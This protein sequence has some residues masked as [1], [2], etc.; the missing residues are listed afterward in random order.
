M[1]FC[2]FTCNFQKL[3]VLVWFCRMFLQWVSQLFIHSILCLLLKWPPGIMLLPKP[4][5]NEEGLSYCVQLYQSCS[6]LMRRRGQWW[7]AAISG[8]VSIIFVCL[9]VVTR[10]WWWW[11]NSGDEGILVRFILCV[12]IEVKF[13]QNKTIST[14]KF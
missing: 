14:M 10:Q 3:Q 12:K 13:F 1:L 2:Y 11:E 9:S 5:V 8:C 4:T 6:L 7:K